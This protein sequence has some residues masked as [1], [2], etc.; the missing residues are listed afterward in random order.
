MIRTQILSTIALLLMAFC[1]PQS[2][3]QEPHNPEISVAHKGVKQLKED[4][5]FF[6]DL[7]ESEQRHWDNWEGMI[8]FLVFGLDF[9]RPLRIDILSGLTPPPIMIYGPYTDPVEDLRDENIGAEYVLQERSETLHEM[10]PTEQGW[11]RILPAQKYAIL[12]PSTPKNHDLLKQ[13]IL[14]AGNPVPVITKILD[15]EANVGIQL[16]NATESE[17][18]LKKRRASFAEIRAVHMDSLQKR[19]EESQTEFEL[20]KGAASNNL[21]ELERLMVESKVAS[22]RAVL[23]KKAVTAKILFDGVGIPGTSMAKGIEMFNK[24]I[25][26]FATAVSPE[27]SAL[28][29][30]I[31]HP[32]DDLR[33]KNTLSFIELMRADVE[34]RLAANTKMTA[35]QKEASLQ[36]FD[37]IMT[38]VKDGVAS[39]N[40]NGFIEAVPNES[41]QFVSHGA[42]VVKDAKRLDETL[43][44]IGKTGGDNEVTIGAETVGDVTIHKVKL[45]KGFLKLFDDVFG[46]EAEILIGTSEDKVWFG[47]GPNALPA[48]KAGIEALKEPAESDVILRSTMQALPWAKRA[49]KLMKD[50]APPKT[51]DGQQKRRDQLRR[52]T[53]AIETLKEEDDDITFDVAAADGRVSGEIFFNSGLL[54]FV[55]TQLVT[56]STENLE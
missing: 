51:L 30:R 17:E 14:K 16:A 2:I 21:N 9:Q 29:F 47:S 7:V 1:G 33:T 43:A 18:D 49:D 22:A 24:Q 23:D 19:P 44:L 38:L 34:S 20:R 5:K 31:N 10:L 48:L 45:G 35:E 26:A 37:G 13:L 25:D 27:G 56:F 6:L 52:L 50:L 12:A 36:L 41:N 42:I 39:E 4:I 32:I 8:E 28:S 46:E 15:G 54:R 40:L 53:Q 3:A 11:F 55:G